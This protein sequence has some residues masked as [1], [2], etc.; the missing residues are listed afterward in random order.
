MEEISARAINAREK[1]NTE[2]MV[3]AWKWPK[4]PHREEAEAYPRNQEY[5][6]IEK[7]WSILEMSKTANFSTFLFLMGQPHHMSVLLKSMLVYTQSND[8]IPDKNKISTLFASI[9]LGQMPFS[10]SSL[11][12]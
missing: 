5:T 1:R 6:A 10:R 8:L 11:S 3:I 4:Q 7:V 12:V 9:S 2:I